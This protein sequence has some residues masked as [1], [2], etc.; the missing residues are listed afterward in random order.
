MKH[1]TV[2]G[3]I[4]VLQ[5]ITVL[6]VF[7]LAACRVP[8]YLLPL[9][10][11]FAILIC[12][13]VAQ[14]SKPILTSL[15][16]VVFTAQ[17]AII[18]GQALNIMQQD[19]SIGWLYPPNSDT[20]N[21]TLLNS[22]VSRTCKASTERYWN[23]VGVEHPWLSSGSI[24]YVAAKNLAPH[25]LRCYYDSL[26][27]YL[28]SDPD[29]A[30]RK[31]LSMRIRYY[32]T[33]D[34]DLYPVPPD[35][36]SQRLNLLNSPILEKV[37]TSGLFEPEPPLAEDPGIL[38]FRRI[39]YISSGRE[40]SDQGEHEQAIETLR[41]ATSL[42]P[43]NAE[44][45]ANLGL[46]YS[47]QGR[48]EEAISAYRQ[49]LKLN[50]DHY[51]AIHLL[52]QILYDQEQWADVTS[53]EQRA[54]KVAP[55]DQQHAASLALL[56]RAYYQLGDTTRACNLFRQAYAIQQSQEIVDVIEALECRD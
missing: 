9:L 8:R 51:W 14:I 22:I 49:V 10:P 29:K 47:R 16:I 38:I 40:L 23:I 27:Y 26:G 35:A 36:L 34:P 25:D 4:A 55:D 6:S 33:V 46:A 19:H 31:I 48:Q 3:A 41:K 39:D 32:V 28:E 12:W 21:A 15:V 45:W 1:F 11:Y 42:E 44:A 13:G 53:L 20:R 7:S 2:C 17:L 50:P 30:W 37:Q 43:S 56:A 18:H 5:I 24:S 52:A 54:V